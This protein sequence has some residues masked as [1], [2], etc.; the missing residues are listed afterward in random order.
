MQESA[1]SAVHPVP[2]REAQPRPR[3][4]RYIAI[5]GHALTVSAA[6]MLGL[7]VILAGAEPTG[8][9]FAIPVVT[10]TTAALASVLWMGRRAQWFSGFI[11]LALT[12][13]VA[14]GLGHLV[15]DSF[16]DFAPI[17]MAF[18]GALIALVAAVA[19]LTRRPE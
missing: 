13:L 12:L 8:F 6:L 10:L 11:G 1:L 16:F 18:V 14:P 5:T 19:E 4:W 3:T 7:S 15:F 17:L 9:A 2:L